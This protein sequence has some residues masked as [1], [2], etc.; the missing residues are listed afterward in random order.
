MNLSLSVAAPTTFY[1][2]FINPSEPFFIMMEALA[3]IA[4]RLL[5][6]LM[7]L[8]DF[9][10]SAAPLAFELNVS[11]KLLILAMGLDSSSLTTDFSTVCSLLL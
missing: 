1:P 8:I 2:N 9:I 4:A 5:L 6:V 3:F 7:K 10:L 11:Y